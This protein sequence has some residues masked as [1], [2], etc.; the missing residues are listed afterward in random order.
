MRLVQ[1]QP[2]AIEPVAVADL[3]THV[4]LDYGFRDHDAMLSLFIKAAR[5]YAEAYTN[6]SFITQGWRG[7]LDGFPQVIELERA[8]VVSVQSIVY[9]DMGGV[10]RTVSDPG[11][12]D[13][14]VDL[15]G[16]LGRI[17]PGFGRIWPIPLPQIGS[18]QV[19]FTAGYGSAATD[20]P[21]EVRH[22]IMLR[23]ATLYRDREESAVLERGDVKPLP[24]VDRLLDPVTVQRA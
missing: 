24:Y 7:T 5:R 12:P 11:L 22:W 14:A 17:T 19:N 10:W 16:P 9:L 21:E 23:A 13:Y 15:S 8:P 20:V 6:R 1:T 3:R 18:V 4:G 2:P